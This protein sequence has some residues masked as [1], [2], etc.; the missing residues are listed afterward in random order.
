MN[1]TVNKIRRILDDVND[2]LQ[3]AY[4]NGDVGGVLEKA[5]ERIATS[6]DPWIKVDDGLP[7]GNEVQP[8]NLRFK[9]AHHTSFGCV[10]NTGDRLASYIKKLA[11]NDYSKSV[12]HWKPIIPPVT[13]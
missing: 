7:E 5:A 12:T 1:K 8:Y 11:T 3:K 13:K 4:D 9:R 10:E 2:D 6:L